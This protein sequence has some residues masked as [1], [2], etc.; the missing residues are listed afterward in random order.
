MLLLVHLTGCMVPDD[1]TNEREEAEVSQMMES[2][3]LTIDTSRELFRIT[4]KK[5]KQS[6]NV[7][8]IPLGTFEY[9]IQYL[10]LTIKANDFP[11]KKNS[12]ESFQITLPKEFQ[13]E[14]LE[15]KL[16]VSSD[17]PIY[18]NKKRYDDSTA[19]V[20]LKKQTIVL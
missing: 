8:I 11:V 17:Q 2:Q 3:T 14:E 4:T 10:D 7:K 5:R 19:T 1:Q 13:E 6:V 16:Y 12:N 18:L 20:F 9:S 15:I